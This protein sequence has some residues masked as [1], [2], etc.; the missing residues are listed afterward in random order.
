MGTRAIGLKSHRPKFSMGGRALE[1]V[2]TNSRGLAGS[3]RRP[4]ALL[5]PHQHTPCPKQSPAGDPGLGLRGMSSR[6]RWRLHRFLA[7]PR[8][9]RRH[10]R[11][12]PVPAFLFPK[13]EQATGMSRTL[14]QEAPKP[15]GSA[16]PGLATWARTNMGRWVP[17]GVLWS[18]GQPESGIPAGALAEGSLSHPDTCTR[19]F[20]LP[21]PGSQASLQ[22]TSLQPL[23]AP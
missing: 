8:A 7:R 13:N 14:C 5:S 10:R 23:P 11:W 3:P 21:Q 19:A 9:P 1:T 4:E 22:H 15:P 18:P 17:P 2:G 6:S 16:A 20:G 12:V